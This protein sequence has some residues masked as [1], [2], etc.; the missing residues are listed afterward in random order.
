MQTQLRYAGFPA[1]LSVGDHMGSMHLKVGVISP[2]VPR[3]CT[4]GTDTDPIV[5][6]PL[7][8][9][10]PDVISPNPLK[11]NTQSA[12]PPNLPQVPHAVR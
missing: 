2:L 3:T 1:F 6:K 5:S 10:G 11:N 4:I 9:A 8:T 12:V 7:R